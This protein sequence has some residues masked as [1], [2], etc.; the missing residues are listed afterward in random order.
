MMNRP[1]ADIPVYLFTGFLGAGKT[2]FIQDVLTDDQFNEGERTLLLL[3]E[4]G[5]AEYDPSRFF[6]KNVFI[7][8]IE[9][10][11]L[12]PENLEKL[13]RKQ[14]ELYAKR[15]ELSE[16]RSSLDAEIQRL[17]MRRVSSGSNPMM[18]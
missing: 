14:K 10:D 7:E 13:Q 15:E 3:C 18:K 11:E 9:E 16:R 5:E 12:E 1:P 4:E 2:T 17:A 8:S 6:C